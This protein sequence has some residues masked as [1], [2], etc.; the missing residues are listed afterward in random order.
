M[1]Y[2]SPLDFTGLIMI[3]SAICVGF[4]AACQFDGD[5]AY[6]SLDSDRKSSWPKPTADQVMIL[7]WV[8]YYGGRYISRYWSKPVYS[9]LPCMGSIHSIYP[10]WLY[11]KY[12]AFYMPYDFFYIWPLI[13]LA[14]VGVNFIITR[15]W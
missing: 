11:L 12:T 8:R 5:D 7:W 3:C 1:T 2:L 6:D 13:A 9:C 10:T 14:T 4:Y 15:L